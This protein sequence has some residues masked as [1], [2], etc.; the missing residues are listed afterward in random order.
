[1]KCALS[2]AHLR[3]RR[4]FIVNAAKDWSK[5]SLDAERSGSATSYALSVT[6][7]VYAWGVNFAG[8][9]GNGTTRTAFTPVLVAS[10]AT[11]ISSTANNVVISGPG[12]R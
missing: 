10:G 11:M 12:G 7:Q 6:G 9:V 5:A 3:A 4:G 1:V 2:M 8:Q